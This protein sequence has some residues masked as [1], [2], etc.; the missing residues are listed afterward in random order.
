MTDHETALA[1][2][3]DIVAP[4]YWVRP[5]NASITRLQPPLFAM[6][7]GRRYV[8]WCDNPEAFQGRAAGSFYTMREAVEWIGP[9]R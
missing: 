6:A 4:G 1:G 7:H 9:T 3:F 8:A 2:G 5:D